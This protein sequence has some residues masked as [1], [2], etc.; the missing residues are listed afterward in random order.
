MAPLTRTLVCQVQVARGGISVN[1]ASRVSLEN[2]TD[3]PIIHVVN[4]SL[5]L[6]W[7]FRPRYVGRNHKFGPPGHPVVCTVSV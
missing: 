1:E 3:S 2:D 6:T 7:A 4:K 5:P